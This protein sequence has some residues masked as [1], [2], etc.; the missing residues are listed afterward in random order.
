M[1]D[2]P[3]PKFDVETEQRFKELVLQEGVATITSIRKQMYPSLEEYDDILL[4][5]KMLQ[6][7]QGECQDG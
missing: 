5:R 7:L 3:V 6:I 4:I 2:I 1:D